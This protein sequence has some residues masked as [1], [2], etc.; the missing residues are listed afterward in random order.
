MSEKLEKGYNDDP[1]SVYM[2]INIIIY[3]YIIIY[4][5]N[6]VIIRLYYKC[7]GE[8]NHVN[9]KIY[10][11]CILTIYYIIPTILSASVISNN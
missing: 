8:F 3:I 2:Y 10:L 6:T 9:K 4:A 1:L 7:I 11:S 5:Y